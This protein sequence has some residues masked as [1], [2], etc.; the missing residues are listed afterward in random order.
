MQFTLKELRARK[1]ETQTET[2][3]GLGVSAVTYN[4]WEKSILNIPIKNLFVISDYF[5]VPIEE[6]K[7]K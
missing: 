5:D 1:D 4:N 7:L 3:E 2:A 6:I